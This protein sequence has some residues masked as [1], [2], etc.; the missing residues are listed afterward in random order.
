LAKSS[1][2]KSEAE[3]PH[4]GYAPGASS[5]CVHCGI[6]LEKRV[7]VKLL[8]ISTLIIVIGSLFLCDLHR[9]RRAPPL[10]SIGDIKP[11]RNFSTVRVKGVL[12]SDAR[13]LQAG[14]ILYRI[15]DGTGTLPV[16][17][18]QAA[19]GKLPKAG[20]RVTAAGSLSVG[21][22]NNVR[23]RALSADQI[24][25][26]PIAPMEKKIGEIRLADI[27][28]AQR[29]DRL[30]IYGRVSK[31]WSPRTDSKAPHKIV[32]ADQSGSLEVIHWFKLERRVKVGDELE[33]TGTVDLYKEKVQLKVWASADISDFQPPSSG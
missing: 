6:R 13:K 27:T 5:R 1:S 25:V 4:C 23:M 29:G 21:A 18:E 19:K 15:D 20:A 28:S 7:G 26:E 16:F 2:S 12:K 24:V 31:V 17:L 10:V 22:G 33:I 14:S 30:T 9:V 3:C 11:I 8:R 32:L